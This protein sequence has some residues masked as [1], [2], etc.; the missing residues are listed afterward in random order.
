MSDVE[1]LCHFTNSDAGGNIQCAAWWPG[2]TLELLWSLYFL[3]VL[4]MI[5]RF[6][7]RHR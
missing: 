2:L 5:Q 7:A 6:P 4:T 3:V 1:K